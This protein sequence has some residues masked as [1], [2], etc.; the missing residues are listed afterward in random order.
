LYWIYYQPEK[1]TA[2][3][4]T[5]S[6]KLIPGLIICAFLVFVQLKII[7][8]Y[9]SKIFLSV[10]FIFITALLFSII[11]A[12]IN[13][14]I[15]NYWINDTLYLQVNN[16]LWS[17][18]NCFIVLLGL[19]GLL[20]VSYYRNLIIQQ[21]E[22][23]ARTKA[24][25]DEAQLIM[26]RYQIN[27]HFL[28]NAL[29]AIQS[30]IEK[31]KIR[32]KDMIADLSDFFRY[33]LSKNNQMS[34]PL[35]EELD[36]IQKYL[37][38]QKERFADKL[39]IE[40]EIDKDSLELKIPFFIIHPLVENAIKYGFL[41][42]DDVLRLLIKVTRNG[43]TLSILVKNT[44]RLV[45]SQQIKDKELISTKTGIDNIKKRLSL[46]YPDCSAFELFEKDQW[47]HALITITHQSMSV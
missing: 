7:I 9:P 16:F 15:Y 11:Q 30:M 1:F 2:I 28:F 18:I 46:F 32:A 40:Y 3:L 31:D 39:D 24:L 14:L 36:A 6:T 23:I 12:F 8:K 45:S 33:T 21:K 47:V 34:V 43:Q 25:A 26:L 20:Y 29:N 27:P 17:V 41:T 44:G 35:K 5:N 10:F 38:I 19:T 42:N 37:A 13:A 22:Q 4:Q